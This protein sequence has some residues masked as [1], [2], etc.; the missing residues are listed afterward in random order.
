MMLIAT[1]IEAGGGDARGYSP[2]KEIWEGVGRSWEGRERG[3]RGERGGLGGK[4][5]WETAQRSTG[6]LPEVEDK[7]IV[8][9]KAPVRSAHY[10]VGQSHM[11]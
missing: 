7:I 9:R 5:P 2:R 1:T 3:G 10:A 11:G 6:D 8:A 4:R